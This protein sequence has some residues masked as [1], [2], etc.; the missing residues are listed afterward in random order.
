MQSDNQPECEQKIQNGDRHAENAVSYRSLFQ[1]PDIEIQIREH[2]KI[3]NEQGYPQV[4]RFDAHH[5]LKHLRKQSH[6]D[7]EQEKHSGRRKERNENDFPK[8]GP[9]FSEKC[10]ADI[11]VRTQ[12]DKYTQQRDERI[13]QIESSVIGRRNEFGQ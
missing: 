5:S 7:R 4:F 13:E 6:N 2:L 8:I 3:A 1:S 12:T 9:A 10:N 11:G